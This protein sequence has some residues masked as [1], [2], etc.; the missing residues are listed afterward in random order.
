MMKLLEEGTMVEVIA[1]GYKE[2]MA[3][4]VG[5]IV[6]RLLPD[7]ET[8]ETGEMTVYRVEFFTHRH[9]LPDNIP[10]YWPVCDLKEIR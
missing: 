3:G 6:E 2:K 4:I 5:T 1:D 10:R 8:N 7:G 9:K